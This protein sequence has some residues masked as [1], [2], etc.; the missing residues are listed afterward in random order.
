MASLDPL[1]VPE[2]P[3]VLW[4]GHTDPDGYGR[5]HGWQTVHR[6]AWQRAYGQIPVGMEIHHLCGNRACMEPDHLE[7][8][9][10]YE[11][12]RTSPYVLQTHCVNGHEYTPENTYIRPNGQR[13]CRACGSA[14]TRAWYARRVARTT[15]RSMA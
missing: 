9:T 5:S 7:C 1:R 13:D 4:T 12:S 8:I 3:C 10:R 6:R 15:D 14:R 11:H 2:T